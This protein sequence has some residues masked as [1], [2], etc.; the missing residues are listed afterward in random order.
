MLLRSLNLRRLSY[1]ILA[2]DKNQFLT[3]LPTIQ[4]KLV[5]IFRSVTSPVVQSEVFICIRVLL[6]R[7]SPHNLTSFWPVI[8]TEMY[9][10]FEQTMAVLPADGSEDLQLVLSA[11]KCL[12]LLL[13][14]QTEEFQIHQWVFITDTID[15][16]YRPNDWFPE[17][18]LDQL[19]EIARNLPLAASETLNTENF[20]LQP[21]SRAIRR[22]LLASLRQIDRM[23][24]L[25]SFFSNVSISTY[26]SVYASAGNIDWEAVEKSILDDM[27]DGR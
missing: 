12:D 3:Q 2:G 22:P 14:L 15:A 16:V 20:V 8:F 4:E 23:R 26:E 5:D 6:C 7:L 21:D 24:D 1:V 9:R 25:V 18:I 13:V 17:A 11:C 27:F 19:S 10:I